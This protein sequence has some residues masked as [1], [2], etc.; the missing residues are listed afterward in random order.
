MFY[1]FLLH[2]ECDDV[3]ALACFVVCCSM[4]QIFN[5]CTSLFSYTYACSNGK[6]AIHL[7]AESGSPH[8]LQTLFYTDLIFSV[9]MPDVDIQD[10]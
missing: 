2:H 8:I 4:R 5:R 10:K 6:T 3:A 1:F 7:A 9:S